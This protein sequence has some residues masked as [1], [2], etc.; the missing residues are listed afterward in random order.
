M[1]SRRVGF[2]VASGFSLVELLVVISI[3][4]LL[5]GLL[6]TA[7]QKSRETARRMTCLNNL[8]QI[9]LGLL[10]YHDANKHFP[11]GGLEMQ[12]M[13]GPKGRQLAWSA[14]ILPYLELSSLAKRVDYKKPYNSA[15]NA[16]AAAEAVPLYLCPS[17]S[18]RSELVSGRG[19]CD[20]G[21][22]HGER[23]YSKNTPPKGVLIYDQPISFR[24][25]I[26]G[27][28]RTMAVSENSGVGQ[29]IN[30]ENTFEVFYTIN[31]APPGDDDIHSKHPDGANGLFAD[32]AARF[33][34]KD[35]DMHILAAICTRNGRET[36]GDF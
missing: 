31:M 17:F 12:F 4:G 28:S 1:S 34:N 5:A 6:I 3:I 18:R 20:Y 13:C 32:G 23:R 21:G 16:K 33:L 24:D 8:R 35:M 7:V 22:I 25:I 14:F 19:A 36:V 27:S 2:G 29:W 15:A 9:G 11:V 30:A 10:A 26:D